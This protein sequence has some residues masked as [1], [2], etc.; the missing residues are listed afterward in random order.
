MNK[1]ETRA[2]L[3][4]RA[5]AANSVGALRA[6]TELKNLG[7]GIVSPETVLAGGAGRAL[8]Q[9]AEGLLAA[10]TRMV[11]ACEREDSAARRRAAEDVL[12]RRLGLRSGTLER[13]AMAAK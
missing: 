5:C 10:A 12:E 13:R 11:V 8:R 7:G 4:G 3:I 9:Q 6:L 2:A 1:F